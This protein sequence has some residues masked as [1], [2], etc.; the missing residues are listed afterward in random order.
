MDV[1][2]LLV[3]YR[4]SID[5]ANA[6]GY[7]PLMTA[8]R[9]GREDMVSFLLSEGAYVDELAENGDTALIL[10]VQALAGA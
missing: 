6:R 2:R 4:A 9:W 10:S 5:A 7:T 8:A 3:D 1:A